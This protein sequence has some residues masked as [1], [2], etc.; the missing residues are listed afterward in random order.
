MQQLIHQTELAGE[1]ASRPPERKREEETPGEG[2]SM[3][4]NCLILKAHGCMYAAYNQKWMFQ[5]RSSSEFSACTRRCC[6]ESRGTRGQASRYRVIYSKNTIKNFISLQL[7]WISI[8]FLSASLCMQRTAAPQHSC[9]W[10][11]KSAETNGLWTSL[12][13][14]YYNLTQFNY[15]CAILD[16]FVTLPLPSR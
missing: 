7:L 11:T 4:V 6:G 10:S 13:V 9:I 2:I 5:R 12:L 8:D 14:F 16:A 3:R 15:N 1:G